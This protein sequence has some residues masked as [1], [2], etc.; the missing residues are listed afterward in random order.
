MHIL[1][2]EY[3]P[4]RFMAENNMDPKK[5]SIELQNLTEIE[6]ML[7]AYVFPVMSIYRLHEGQNGY[8]GNVINFSQNVQEI[9]TKLPQH[10][11]S[12]YTSSICKQFRGIKRF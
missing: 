8:H 5:V 4:K 2:K 11:S 10:P 1:S 3:L 9:A 12:C 7:I 6:K